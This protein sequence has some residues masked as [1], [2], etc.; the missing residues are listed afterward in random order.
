M[1]Y[2]PPAEYA[3]ALHHYHKLM[4]AHTAAL[5]HHFPSPAAAAAAAASM[6]AKDLAAK[7]QQQQQ[8]RGGDYYGSHQQQHSG[9]GARGHAAPAPGHELRRDGGAPHYAPAPRVSRRGSKQSA[10]GATAPPGAAGA[11]TSH[12]DTL[13]EEF[14]TSKSRKFEMRD[15]TGCLFEFS[16][17]QHGSRFIQQKLESLQPT[18]YAA[19]LEEVLPRALTL[20]TDV[21]GNYVIQK[22]LEHGSSAGRAALCA[23]LEGHVLHLS[24]HMY[25]CRV[26]Q[27]A[28]EVAPLE[29][30]LALASELEAHVLRCVKD[31][32]GGA[33]LRA[34]RALPAGAAQRRRE[35]C[36]PLAQAGPPHPPSAGG[37]ALRRG[38]RHGPTRPTGHAAA[39]PL[40]LPSPSPP[41][42]WPPRPATQ[43]GNHVI[44]K[45][46][47]RVP[48]DK[49][50]PVIDTFLGT[51]VPLSTH[52]FG[53]RVV[54]RIL[55]HCSDP[56]KRK[57]ALDE[58]LRA[59]VQL[60]QDQ[61]G[62]PPPPPPPTSTCP[63]G[64]PLPRSGLVRCLR[65]RS[66]CA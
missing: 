62:A 41:P 24:L 56:K 23:Q 18:E 64:A 7:E 13:L 63:A 4:E 52:P 34:A 36:A 42:T 60:A 35:R 8:H 53:C 12:G 59:T 30:Q 16:L 44:Q 33:P 37:A 27:K 20:M 28:V 32:V 66:C 39:A 5:Q 40:P 1:P 19:A 15:I 61:Y 26:V 10:S 55:E 6:A 54:Q 3:A 45:V 51:V 50:A 29:R 11:C 9:S 14:K 48:S 17:D 38:S 57:I 47:E 25:G 43:N 58:I 31:Q 65:R 21:F 2:P 49:I 22:F 46:I